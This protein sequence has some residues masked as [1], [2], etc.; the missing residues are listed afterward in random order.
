MKIIKYKIRG[1]VLSFPK[2]WSKDEIVEWINTDFKVCPICN[3]VDVRHNHFDTC[4][5]VMQKQ[6]E[7]NNWYKY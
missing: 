2:D 7:L 5:T 6:K 4:N 1:E 3:K